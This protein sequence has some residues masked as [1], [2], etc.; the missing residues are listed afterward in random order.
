MNLINIGNKDLELLI[1]L[2]F[3]LFIYFIYFQD[4]LKEKARG[5]EDY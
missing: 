4:A 2:M 3:L 1:S 5:D